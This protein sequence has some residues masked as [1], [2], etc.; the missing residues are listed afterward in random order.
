MKRS[1]DDAWT[2]PTPSLLC[3]LLS[4][5]SQAF[6]FPTS[7]EHFSV[8]VTS[9]A[10][11]GTQTQ[12]IQSQTRNVKFTPP[13]I[14]FMAFLTLIRILS[15][16]LLFCK[17]DPRSKSEVLDSVC[18]IK[19]RLAGQWWLHNTVNIVSAT[20]LDLERVKAIMTHE[21]CHNGNI[22]YITKP[23]FLSPSFAY[24]DW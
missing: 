15:T 11:Q 7:T 4:R 1:E 19:K 14:S 18:K 13:P 22:Y 10:K 5:R 3:S 9:C 6:P 23:E 12:P 8:T 20:G 21:S 17:R 2:T 16:C 24:E